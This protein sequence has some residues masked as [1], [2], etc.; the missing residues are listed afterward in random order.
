M[1][2]DQRRKRPGSGRR[3][4]TEVARHGRMNI[5][6]QSSTPRPRT[7]TLGQYHSIFNISGHRAAYVLC[8]SYCNIEMYYCIRKETHDSDSAR[9]RAYRPAAFGLIHRELG[10]TI[11]QPCIGR[12][13]NRLIRRP[14]PFTYAGLLRISGRNW[15]GC[16]GVLR[17]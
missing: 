4:E 15:M 6:W 10:S 13:W 3:G 7:R 17:V 8:G 11:E 2:L 9:Q 12:N 16:C 1:D 5:S 14:P